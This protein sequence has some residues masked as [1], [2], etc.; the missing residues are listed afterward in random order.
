MIVPTPSVGGL[1]IAGVTLLAILLSV[2]LAAGQSRQSG[3]IR[4]TVTDSSGGVIAGVV[5]T[6]NNLATGV[7]QRPTTDAT[8]LY[9][10]A[11]VPVGPYSVTFSKEGFKQFIR[12]N[13]DMRLE[14]ITLN[15]AARK[16]GRRHSPSR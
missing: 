5:V 12:S 10:A 2:G 6:I 15:A 13:V 9:D 1:R 3:E 16:L 11:S 7:V 4:G 8:G 14:T